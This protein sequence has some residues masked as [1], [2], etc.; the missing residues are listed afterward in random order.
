M[1][2]PSTPSRLNPLSFVKRL[3]NRPPQSESPTSAPT[4]TP[5]R[6]PREGP[7]TDSSF[8]PRSNGVAAPVFAGES[9]VQDEEHR[10]RRRPRRRKPSGNGQRPIEGAQAPAQETSYEPFDFGGV[11]LSGENAPGPQ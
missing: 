6:P 2:T 10:K 7:R 5:S 8:A 4:L 1:P 3:L 11:T 9:A